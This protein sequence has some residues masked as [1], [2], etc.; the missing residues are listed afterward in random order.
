[1]PEFSVPTHMPDWIKNHVALYLE[2]PAEGHMWD[3]SVAGGK[4]P[5]PT[6]LLATTGK[7]SGKART[8]PLI[9]SKTD[10]NFVVI[11][12]RGGSPTHPDWYLNLTANPDVSIKVVDDEY[13]AKARSATGAEREA[14]WQ[15]M[16]E[17]YPP[18]NA[19]QQRAGRE[20]PVVVLEPVST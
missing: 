7:R 18:Y 2:N 13:D 20:I 3:S 19:Y 6:L 11:A 14:L 12:S 10:G 15:Q 4:G 5:V 9:Y 8:V 17:L 1:M 16:A